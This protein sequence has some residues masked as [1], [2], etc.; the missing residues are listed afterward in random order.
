M[1]SCS[2]HDHGHERA[3]YHRRPHCYGA[4]PHVEA[5]C[6]QLQ[7]C[8]LDFCSDPAD[9]RGQNATWADV[10]AAKL[11][12][13]ATG[14][15]TLSIGEGDCYVE[16]KTSTVFY[17]I[18]HSLFSRMWDHR[19]MSEILETDENF[20]VVASTLK[21]IY[22]QTC[23]KC[24]SDNRVIFYQHKE[25][26]TQRKLRIEH[27]KGDTPAYLG[28]RQKEQKRMGDAQSSQTDKR[29]R[30]GGSGYDDSRR[31]E[32]GRWSRGK[33]TPARA[34]AAAGNGATAQTGP[35]AAIFTPA[36]P[37]GRGQGPTMSNSDRL[38]RDHL[39]SGH[40]ALPTPLCQCIKTAYSAVSSPF[41]SLRLLPC[42][43]VLRT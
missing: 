7:Q 19:E 14:Q 29:L 34:P 42:K 9:R 1:A 32:R 11:V 22:D 43:G 33:M 30:E 28:N 35:R 13:G 36:A 12:V 31:S 27:G 4:D 15:L 41:S 10:T 8:P 37:V 39:E 20:E 26:R 17:G 6:H 21:C 2:G 3:G 16:L 5:P 24:G 25:G 38:F 23:R 18:I 40:F